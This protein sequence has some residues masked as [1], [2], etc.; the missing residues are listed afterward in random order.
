MLL[1]DIQQNTLVIGNTNVRKLSNKNL[2]PEAKEMC[3]FAACQ[4]FYI[5][6]KK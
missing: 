4:V 1:D 2:L 6:Q 3:N 5:F